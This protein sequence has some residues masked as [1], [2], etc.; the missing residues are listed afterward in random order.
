[1][2]LELHEQL[3][4][5][6]ASGETKLEDISAERRNELI[7][8]HLPQVKLIAKR[9]RDRLPVSASL[10]DLISAG[11]L[12]LIAAVDRYSEAHDVK[13][14][15]YAE[16]KIRGAI[17]D[18]LRIMD[19]APRQQRKRY[20]LIQTAISTLEQDLQR[21]P[22]E[23]EIAVQ[24]GLPISEFHQW[25]ADVPGLT[26]G[27]L[28]QPAYEDESVSLLQLI[29]N[30][31]DEWP[32]VVLERAERERSLAQVITKLPSVERTVLT[33]YFYEELTLREISEVVHLHESRIS[34][35]K[36]QAISRLRA[37]MKRRWSSGS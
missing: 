5:E 18:S 19:W 4:N 24:L 25:M 31:E 33:L 10:D 27:S 14:K 20:K 6:G 29:A 37:Y 22:S 35:L 28:E 17:L 13:L 30:S 16:Y 26:L 23:E 7:L 36:T 1:M 2:V 34:Q 11:V 3:Q 9:I 8:A 12:G 15:T 32:S 21:M